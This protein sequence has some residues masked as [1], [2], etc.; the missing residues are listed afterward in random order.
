MATLTGGVAGKRI[1][2][3]PGDVDNL[4]QVLNEYQA[5]EVRNG[6]IVQGVPG[7]K[8]LP[9]VNAKPYLKT[10]NEISPEIGRELSARLAQSKVMPIETIQKFWPQAQKLVQAGPGANPTI[11]KSQL[12]VI[13]VQ[14]SLHGYEGGGRKAGRSAVDSTGAPIKRAKPTSV[15]LPAYGGGD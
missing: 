5:A 1:K 7:Y 9:I 11:L 4:I 10:I 13:G 12:S 3:N 6:L 2:L 15:P 14:A 8:H